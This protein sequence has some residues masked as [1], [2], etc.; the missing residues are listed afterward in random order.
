M[1]GAALTDLEDASR[2]IRHSV[3]LDGVRPSADAI[4]AR[5]YAYGPYAH[6]GSPVAVD[7]H[8]LVLYMK[9]RTSIAR[10]IGDTSEDAEV[11]PGDLSLQSTR[12]P[13]LWR[14]ANPIEVLHVYI[15]PQHLRSMAQRAFDRDV[16]AVKLHNRLRATDETIVQLGHDLVTELTTPRAGSD[17]AARAI[18]E[19]LL[20]QLLR[21]HAEIERRDSAQGLDAATVARLEAYVEEHLAEGLELAQL[22]RVTGY[23]VHH[24]CRLFRQSF[25]RSPHDYI[26]ARRVEAAKQLLATS[27]HGIGEIALACGFAD[28]SHLTRCFKSHVGVTPGRW[29]SSLA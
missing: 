27:P 14:W 16:H 3:W 1:P 12:M 17:I 24:F 4:G 23:G 8:V 18:G 13:S 6:D 19:R 7:P 28:Q 29:R 20:V 5:G 21:S 25:D 2:E 9:G 11:G 26:R 22:A 15:T 10:V